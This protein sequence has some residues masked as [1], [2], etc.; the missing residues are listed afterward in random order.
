MAEVDEGGI[1][2]GDRDSLYIL[3]LAMIPMRTPALRRARI[4]KNVR[5]DSVIELFEDAKCG[6]GQIGIE[7]LAHESGWHDAP[8]HPD[9]V[10]L[11]KLKTLPSFDVYSLRYSC[12][13]TRSRSTISSSCACRRR[14]TRNSPPT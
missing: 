5:L 2:D 11:R 6:S 13:R 10:I 12:A 8:R 14:R 3:P 4:I 9:L 7:D 1:R